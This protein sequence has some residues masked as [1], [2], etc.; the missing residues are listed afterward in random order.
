MKPNWIQRS[1][2]S[3]GISQAGSDARKA[4]Q[5]AQKIRSLYTGELPERIHEFKKRARRM[6]DHE[7]GEGAWAGP[8][9]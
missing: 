2:P 9:F 3:F 1:L 5:L 8:I 4:A 6:G 7:G